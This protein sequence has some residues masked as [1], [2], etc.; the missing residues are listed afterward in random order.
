MQKL[1]FMVVCFLAFRGSIQAAPPS[2]TRPHSLPAD[3]TDSLNYIDVKAM[4]AQGDG[5]TNDSA[6]LRAA[7]ALACSEG[8]NLY[9]PPGVYNLGDLKKSQHVIDIYGAR[10]MVISGNQ[11]TLIC[12]STT[13]G[14][15]QS[16]P[17][18][19]F[20]VSDSRGITFRGLRFVDGGYSDSA[21]Y[22]GA[23]GIYIPATSGDVTNVIVENVEGSSV[24]GLMFRAYSSSR[25]ENINIRNVRV[26]KSYYGFILNDPRNLRISTYR[27]DSL[28]RALFLTGGQFITADIHSNNHQAASA[29]VLLKC[30]GIPLK[31]VRIHYRS[32]NSKSAGNAFVS[33]EQQGT[34]GEFLIDNVDIDVDC[35]GS[36]V[37]FPVVIKALDAEGNI[38]PTTDKH[39]DN[40]RIRG[41]SAGV[42]GRQVQVLS[43]QNKPGLIEV[44]PQLDPNNFL[45]SYYPG[46]VR[47]TGH[48][49]NYTIPGPLT[50]ASHFI[51]LSKFPGFPGRVGTIKVRAVLIENTGLGAATSMTF[52]EDVL[53]VSVANNGIVTIINQANLQ[54]KSTGNTVST[55]SYTAS[56]TGVNV[57]FS[58][59]GNSLSVGYLAA[60]PF[61]Q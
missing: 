21:T 60:E 19:I 47:L 28:K 53:F 35:S 1:L 20:Q 41:L 52:Q 13:A 48:T 9:F 18:R 33:L 14:D 36:T 5:V 22:K 59:Y 7:A 37:G 44:S 12:R 27:A 49:W 26:E 50:A 15:N 3:I 24:L 46:F 30:Y 61:Q 31:N 56:G 4:G 2:F 16:D 6:A 10:G 39:W 11:A 57:T 8:K 55:A 43:I 42:P 54:K 34:S 45:P 51:D 40:I 29:E 38:V 25:F 32:D 23:Y 17:P 58:G